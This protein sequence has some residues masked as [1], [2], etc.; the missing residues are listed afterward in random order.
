M[1]RDQCLSYLTADL[2]YA[3]HI[4]SRINPPEHKHIPW[5]FTFLQI[6]LN[7]HTAH[8]QCVPRQKSYNISVVVYIAR[9]TKKTKNK[10]QKILSPAIVIGTPERNGFQTSSVFSIPS[11]MILS[12]K[13]LR[14]RG[15]SVFVC[16]SV[17]RAIKLGPAAVKNISSDM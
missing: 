10:N 8:C 13:K 14:Y 17:N 5:Y 3:E 6:V 7:T 1:S 2:V 4:F 12:S 9:F 16:Q 11:Q 15:R